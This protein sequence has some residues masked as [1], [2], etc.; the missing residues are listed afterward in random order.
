VKGMQSLTP[1]FLHVAGER[2]LR[3]I[4]SEADLFQC[5]HMPNVSLLWAVFYLAAFAHAQTFNEETVRSRERGQTCV[6]QAR[7]IPCHSLN[8]HVLGLLLLSL[9]IGRRRALP[10]PVG[11][12]LKPSGVSKMIH[13][14]KSWMR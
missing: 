13:F 2:G 10:T 1:L 14:Q 11:I 3:K 7:L 6:M 5:L 9:Y 8:K 12:S 4:R